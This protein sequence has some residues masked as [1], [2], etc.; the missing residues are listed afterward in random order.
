MILCYNFNQTNRLQ[1]KG[2]HMTEERTNYAATPQP[3]PMTEDGSTL[4]LPHVMQALLERESTRM[5]LTRL[6]TLV[7][8]I[9]DNH[10]N[11][12]APKND[13][14]NWADLSTEDVGLVFNWRGELSWTVTVAEASPDATQFQDWLTARLYEAGYMPVVVKTEW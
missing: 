6:R 7:N 2:E 12:D 1:A 14:V 8:A 9:L 11:L 10:R 13:A 4:V 5:A 3:K